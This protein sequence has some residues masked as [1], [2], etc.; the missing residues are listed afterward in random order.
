MSL[1]K[2]T[3]I[4][5]IEINPRRVIMKIKRISFFIGLLFVIPLCSGCVYF[6][7]FS[8]PVKQE[9][10]VVLRENDF[11]VDEVNLVGK[12]S[13]IY[14]FGIIP[15]QD[16]RIFSRALADLYKNR[17]KKVTGAPYQFTNWGLDSTKTNYI[18]F[19]K[20]EVV[21][22]SDLIKFDK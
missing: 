6:S 11:K 20:D 17:E 3:E 22:R 4:T 12:A 13:C 16:Q 9:V 8:P 1:L 21:F 5:K 19:V 14:L 2:I 7:R 10:E 18:V 15:L